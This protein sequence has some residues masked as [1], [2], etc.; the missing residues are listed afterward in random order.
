MLEVA[1]DGGDNLD[2]QRVGE[3]R[4]RAEAE[5]PHCATEKVLVRRAGGGVVVH[6]HHAG[7]IGGALGHK[8]GRDRRVDRDQGDAVAGVEQG[9]HQVLKAF[10][11][12]DERASLWRGVV[13][14]GWFGLCFFNLLKKSLTLS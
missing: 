4:F 14:L 7:I 11:R 12:V 8:Q 5:P 10:I 3:R 2:N 1:V 13:G 6:W 9:A